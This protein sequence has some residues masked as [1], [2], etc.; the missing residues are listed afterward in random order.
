MTAF[1]LTRLYGWA[2]KLTLFASLI[3]SKFGAVGWRLRDSN[4]WRTWLLSVVLFAIV[5]T[6]VPLSVVAIPGYFFCWFVC[7]IGS[8]ILMEGR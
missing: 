5:W 2:G 1:S 6:V 3:A 8:W 7:L 4:R